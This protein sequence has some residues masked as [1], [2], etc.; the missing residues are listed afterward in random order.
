MF[1]R[2]GIVPW[3]GARKAGFGLHLSN[4]GKFILIG[5]R[6]AHQILGARDQVQ[7]IAA[8]PIGFLSDR[9]CDTPRDIK[10]FPTLAKPRLRFPRQDWRNQR[11][12]HYCCG[13]LVGPGCVPKR[14]RCSP[15]IQ[16]QF[17]AYGAIKDNIAVSFP[18]WCQQP[19][20]RN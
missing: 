19:D 11:Y 2:I 18:V 14:Y 4:G 10:P 15:A 8:T 7:G 5:W 12:F 13:T 1:F 6:K 9:S 3:C 16:H 20:I 17:G